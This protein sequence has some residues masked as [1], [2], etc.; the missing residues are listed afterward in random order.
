MALEKPVPWE[1]GF[2]HMEGNSEA[3]LKAILM[4]LSCTIPVQEGNLQLGFWQGAYLC[5]FDGPRSRIVLL[6]VH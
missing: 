4:G 3:H 5:E 6:G 1:Q 2:R